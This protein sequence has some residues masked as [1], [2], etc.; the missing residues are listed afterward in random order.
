MGD[1]QQQLHVGAA[2]VAEVYL[3]RE[4][5][6]QK[7]C[8]YIER[9]G[10][11]GIDLLVFPEFHV[12]ASPHLYTYD[13]S[14]TFEEFYERLFENAV[15]VPGP[16]IDEI[17][18]AA[19]EANTAV[20]LGINEKRPNTAGTLYN[21]LVFVDADGTLLGVRRKLMPTSTERLFHAG[22]SGEDVRVFESS[23]GT[24]GGLVCG[25]HTN[26][27]AS[28]SLLALNEELHAAAWPAFPNYDREARERRIGIRTRYHAFTGAVPTVAASGVIN[29]EL[30]ESVGR[31]GWGADSGTSSIIAPDGQYLA[32]PK[33]EG[34][35]I[36][37]AHIDLGERTRIKSKHDVVGHYNRFDIFDVR[38]NQKPHEPIYFDETADSN[39]KSL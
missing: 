17:C 35:G 36:V 28:Y 38:V 32:G 4:E 19:K 9:A 33:W 27:L 3:D 13:D 1:T 30:A 31:P 34:E 5:T 39:T 26:H 16:A 21:S 23:I 29:E 2:Q 25:E 22:G 14:Y 10:K 6:I 24:L 20:V 12:P 15:T 8:T 37:S 7:D 11:Q 18:A